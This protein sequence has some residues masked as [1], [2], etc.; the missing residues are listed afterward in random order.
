[1]TGMSEDVLECVL[2]PWSCGEKETENPPARSPPVALGSAKSLSSSA[3]T[4][5]RLITQKHLLSAA[6]SHH[7]RITT[8]ITTRRIRQLRSEDVV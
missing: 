1:M 3:H 8:S 4:S 6:T 7:Q 5:S 2:L